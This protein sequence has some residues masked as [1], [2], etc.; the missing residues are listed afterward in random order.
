MNYKA[1][2][3]SV[4]LPANGDFVELLPEDF[5][6]FKLLIQNKGSEDIEIGFDDNE[7]DLIVLCSKASLGEEISVY[8]NRLT[9]KSTN[10]T[11]GTVTVVYATNS[12]QVTT[13]S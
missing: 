8:G 5:K 13:R 11:E 6:R 3:K 12:L 10:N 9:A 7:D 1:K 4:T 2:V